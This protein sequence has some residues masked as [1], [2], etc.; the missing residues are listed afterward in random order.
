[1]S[2][3][4]ENLA[5]KLAR[6]TGWTY[7]VLFG[8]TTFTAIPVGA[9]VIGAFGSLLL[10]LFPGLALVYGIKAAFLGDRFWWFVSLFALTFAT[11]IIA[12]TGFVDSM[13]AILTIPAYF[14]TFFPLVT[15]LRSGRPD[16]STE[17]NGRIYT[18]GYLTLVGAFFVFVWL[19]QLFS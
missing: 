4:K 19:T 11:L 7:L 6:I 9:G 2:P 3:R 16:L 12:A 17:P 8:L 13:W 5:V 1:M 15:L 14:F 10:A 18:Y